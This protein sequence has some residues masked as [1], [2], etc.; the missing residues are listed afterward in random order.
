VIEALAET[1][2]DSA[3]HRAG[4]H[5]TLV[6]ATSPAATTGTILQPDHFT[7]LNPFMA[8][9]PIQD[10]ASWVVPSGVSG[11]RYLNLVASA[12]LL[13]TLETAPDSNI[14]IARDDGR[15]V[16]QRWRPPAP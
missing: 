3:F 6:L 2:L 10:S 7:E 11:T 8:S 15:L 14:S 4:V 12:Q 13:Q 1:E 5:T 9:L 16:V